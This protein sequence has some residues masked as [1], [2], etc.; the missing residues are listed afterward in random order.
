MT[1]GAG[2][3]EDGGRRAVIDQRIGELV[4]EMG[5]VS[6]ERLAQAEQT[7][8]RDGQRFGEHLVV[9]GLLH[10]DDLTHA[11]A[12]QHN[13]PSVN[14]AEVTIAAD[15]LACVP[16]DLAQ[17][18]R[19][20]PLALH[21]D[22]LEL[23]M[24]DPF[25]LPALDDLSA[26]CGYDIVRRHVRP[27]ELA[28]ALR[29]HY[30]T[31]AARMADSLAAEQ[32]DDE[33]AEPADYVG[34]LHE[35]AR[36]PSL[37]NLLNLIV[38]EA[39]QDK[40]SD[41]HIEPF[42]KE[43]KV[44][45]R[46]DGVLHEMSPPPK[47]LQAAIIS[48]IKIM[49]NLNI[50]ERFVPQDGHI[51]FA[52]ADAQVDI[53]V[54]T[55]PTMFG[56]SVV[57]RILDKTNTL[58]QLTDLGLSTGMLK[59][60]DATLRKPHGILLV[61][62]PTGSGK[63]TTLYAAL[64]HIF[65]PGKKIITIEDPVEFHLHGVNQMQVNP[66]RGLTFANGL[67]SILRQDPDIIMVG[68]IRDGETADIAIR[69]ALTGHLVFSSLHTNDASGAVTRLL[70]MGLEP[71]LLATTVETVVAQRLLRLVCER[72]AETY[73]PT[74]QVLEQLGAAAQAFAGRTLRRGR[75]CEDC[76]NTGYRGRLGIFELL[77][78]T[79]PIRDVILQ[80]PSSSQV[81]AAAGDAFV[82]MREDGY[83][84]V[85]DGR[86]TLEEVWRVTQ[87]TLETENGFVTEFMT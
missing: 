70:D 47:H 30:G 18:Y 80:R 5:Y 22:R 26:V 42:E 12:V 85:L 60:F 53:R 75:G 64:N 10:R 69:S 33:E 72:C 23:A 13:I 74:D 76:H 41:I 27:A 83:R 39:I 63:T 28:E 86:T 43:L 50:A 51:K 3:N 36:E 57:L 32:G 17:R 20:L 15:A 45:Y 40:A 65:T 82:T 46:I 31:S 16:A 71:F 7:P 38:I 48:R 9:M 59:T 25:D 62:G 8:R 58:R 52:T 78:I 6:P 1:L 81:R 49:A 67:R 61:T 35:L 84:K 37:I 79:D 66:R 68:E 2:G 19:V 44:K 4:V 21:E 87:D 56:E 24:A 11:L 77:R 34:H 55:V 14:L 73:T 54:S 29:R